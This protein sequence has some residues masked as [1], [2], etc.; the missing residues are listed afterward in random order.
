M[1]N[2]VVVSALG[3][4]V[5]AAS[6]NAADLARRPVA[7]APAPLPPAYSWTGFY[8]G[9]HAGA[10][11]GNHDGSAVAI[12]GTGTTAASGVVGSESNVGFIG[13]AQG[14]FNYALTPNWMLGVEGDFTWTDISTSQ[15]A[16]L[17]TAGGVAVPGSVAFTRDLNWLAS[18]RGRLGY[19]WDRFMVY[20]TGGAAWADYD[21]TAFATL[22]TGAVAGG[23]VSDK[24]RSGW[25]AGGGVEW[26][27]PSFWFAGDWTARVE[28]LHY[29]FSSDSPSAVFVPGPG[30]A[31]FSF[32][33]PTVDV[34]RAGLSYKFGSVPGRG[35]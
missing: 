25:V 23:S 34:V 7:P 9:G 19:T 32:G 2:L 8:L 3:L 17:L 10:G 15:S 6:A 4:F 31:T 20:G 12:T 33:D 13:G 27:I 1:R 24:T 26:A 35:W 21:G 14:G 28:Y 5:S 29:D 22:A 18:V 30:T 16:G 11:W